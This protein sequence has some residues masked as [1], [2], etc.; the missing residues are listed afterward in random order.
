MQKTALPRLLPAQPSLEHLRKEA[1]QQL[2]QLRA[3][4]GSVQLA[5]AQYL[6][7][8]TYGFSSWQSL[9]L[10]VDRRREAL[11]LMPPIILGESF[12]RPRRHRT[13]V[14]SPVSAEHTFS[15]MSALMMLAL[16]ARPVIAILGILFS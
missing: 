1:K 9:K 4:A 8:R 16:G 3:R 10:E 7:A 11:G 13:T 5:D 12:P 14:F 6:V 2:V 15:A